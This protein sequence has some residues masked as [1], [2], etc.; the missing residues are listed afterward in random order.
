MRQAQAQREALQ[1][2]GDRGDAHAQGQ[3]GRDECAFSGR[4]GRRALSPSS[5][6]ATLAATGTDGA[7][8]VDKT[9]RF[10]VVR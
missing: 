6:K 8:S 4:L 3:R 1:A 2:V 9:V 5:Y 10:R 7:R